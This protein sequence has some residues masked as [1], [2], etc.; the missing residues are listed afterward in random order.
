MS[1]LK[2]K[3][4]LCLH[5]KV[6]IARAHRECWTNE[7]GKQLFIDHYGC[8]NYVVCCYCKKVIQAEHTTTIFGET[9]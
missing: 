1:F 5:G 7:H 9:R 2:F 8:Y 3:Q 6:T 4:M